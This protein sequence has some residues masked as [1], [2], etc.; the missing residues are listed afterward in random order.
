MKAD[1]EDAIKQ[2]FQTLP[3][4]LGVARM[5]E[6]YILYSGKKSWTSISSEVD[7]IDEMISCVRLQWQMKPGKYNVFS[8]GREF[9]LVPIGN[10][11]GMVHVVC[12]DKFKSMLDDSSRR[13]NYLKN[14]LQE[15][16]VG[17]NASLRKHVLHSKF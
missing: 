13:T 5:A 7:R 10:I 6:N 11:K 15:L 2:I 16:R 14:I 4:R 3:H 1:K 8:A 17:S 9:D 12:K